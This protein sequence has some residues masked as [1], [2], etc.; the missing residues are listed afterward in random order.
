MVGIA[1]TAFKTNDVGVMYSISIAHN[2]RI[3]FRL[4]Y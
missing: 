1:L 4:C 2:A 3:D